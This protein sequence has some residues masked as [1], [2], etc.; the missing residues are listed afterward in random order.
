MCECTRRQ[1]M[2]KSTIL[3]ALT[4]LIAGSLFAE[5]MTKDAV[6]S[7]TEKF[8]NGKG[9]FV[10]AKVKIENNDVT[11]YTLRDQIKNF[12]IRE[13]K[14]VTFLFISGDI[15]IYD[16][17]TSCIGF[18]NTKMPDFDSKSLAFQANDISID[19][20]GNLVIQKN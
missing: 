19:S 12:E 11:L 10:K 16:D 2:K 18:G 4:A 5:P 3:I 9:S 20:N 1:F 15:C 13:N 17:K 7:N 8:L 6:F 14:G